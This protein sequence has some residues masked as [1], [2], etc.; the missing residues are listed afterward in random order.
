MDRQTDC[1]STPENRTLLADPSAAHQIKALV[2]SCPA[3]S[4]DTQDTAK[5]TKDEQMQPT[6]RIKNH[7]SCAQ[8]QLDSNS[9]NTTDGY[10]REVE[11]YSEKYVC[12]NSGHDNDDTWRMS[13]NEDDEDDENNNIWNTSDE[14]DE[15][16]EEDTD[17]DED[18]DWKSNNGERFD[19]ILNRARQKFN[20]KKIEGFNT[21]DQK[22]LEDVTSFLQ[23]VGCDDLVEELRKIA[24]NLMN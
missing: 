13:D 9:S 19:T 21:A 24:S 16:S 5:D 7:Q 6:T 2:L 15:P 12:L 20:Q 22:S 11:N 1:T 14:E 18:D 8:S 10:E 17:D 4:H 23:D 3:V